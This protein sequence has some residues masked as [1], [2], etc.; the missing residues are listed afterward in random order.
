VLQ[1]AVLP[2]NKKNPWKKQEPFEGGIATVKKDF[3]FFLTR[4]YKLVVHLD[5][6]TIFTIQ[7]NH[8]TKRLLR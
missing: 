4:F 5:K 3:A 7:S 6:T 1:Q 8:K 2:V